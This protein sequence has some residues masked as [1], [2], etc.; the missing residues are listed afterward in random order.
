MDTLR[1]C[2]FKEAQRDLALIVH[3]LFEEEIPVADEQNTVVLIP[4]T[5]EKKVEAKTLIA[6]ILHDSRR[7]LEKQF[8]KEEGS[9]PTNGRGT[10][11][12]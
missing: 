8:C 2:L 3:K 4:V 5:D 6:N 10:I 12:A 7:R 11:Q 9:A 1:Q